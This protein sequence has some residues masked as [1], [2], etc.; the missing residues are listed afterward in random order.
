MNQGEVRNQEAEREEQ[1]RSRAQ[2]ARMQAH[3]SDN[4]ETNESTPSAER[5]AAKTRHQGEARNKDRHQQVRTCGQSQCRKDEAATPVPLPQRVDEPPSLEKRRGGGY[6]RRPAARFAREEFDP[7]PARPESSPRSSASSGR[8][9]SS[10][11]H[12]RA[13]ASVEKKKEEEK[14]KKKKKN[15]NKNEPSHLRSRVEDETGRGCRREEGGDPFENFP[16]HLRPQ[17]NKSY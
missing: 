13:T 3:I 12:T 4:D 14:M 11:V 8:G 1:R 9:L 2:R 17:F 10:S 15:K 6:L 16:P 5:K 7:R